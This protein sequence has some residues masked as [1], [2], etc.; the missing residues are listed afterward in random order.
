MRD[1]KA[2]DLVLSE[3][4]EKSKYLD[5][6]SLVVNTKL[7]ELRKGVKTNNDFSETILIANSHE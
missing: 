4:S 1:P 6:V 7:E 2:Q 5:K 3:A